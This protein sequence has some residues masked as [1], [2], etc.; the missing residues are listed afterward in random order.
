M[1]D[2]FGKLGSDLR[3]NLDL[4]LG[5]YRLGELGN[6]A[7]SELGNLKEDGLAAGVWD[8]GRPGEVEFSI[9][10]TQRPRHKRPRNLRDLG[11][12]GCDYL[13]GRGI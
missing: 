1:G 11:T 10:D 4:D 13:G 3:L 2:T 8:L 12:W 9:L 6:A 7:V 5:I